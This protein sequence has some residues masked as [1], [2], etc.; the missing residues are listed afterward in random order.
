MKKH[1]STNGLEF[2]ALKCAGKP[3]ATSKNKLVLNDPK[4]GVYLYQAN[5]LELMDIML[6]KYHEGCFDMIFVDPPYFLSNGGITCQNGRMV[7]VNKGAWDKSNGPEINHS[8]NLE[9]LKRCQGLLKPNGTIWVSG[10]MHI[11]YSIG[12]AMQELSFKILNDII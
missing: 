4:I 12:Y 7:S 11:I 5:C 2:D 3:T 1:L 6:L 9:W 8:F 10:T